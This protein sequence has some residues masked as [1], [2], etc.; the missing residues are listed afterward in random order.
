VIIVKKR[1]ELALPILLTL[2]LSFS[3]VYSEAFVNPPA[4]DTHT[5]EQVKEKKQLI[6]QYMK[7]NMKLEKQIQKKYKDI[8]SLLTDLYENNT[9]TQAHIEYQIKPKMTVITKNIKQAGEM[10]TTIWKHLNMAKNSMEAKDHGM[11]MHHMGNAAEMLEKKH[12]LLTELNSSMDEFL[13]FL[14]SLGHK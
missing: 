10:Q 11:A 3:P 2:I 14:K 1:H 13:N 9:I 6:K 4:P 5:M 7:D 12:A 8:Q